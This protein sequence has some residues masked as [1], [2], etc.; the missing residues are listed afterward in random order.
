MPD[1][2]EGGRRC[3]TYH[4]ILYH[5]KRRREARWTAP[6]W[7]SVPG[8]C[9]GA[10]GA[11]PAA[12]GHTEGST[13]VQAGFLGRLINDFRGFAKPAG[14]WLAGWWVLPLSALWTVDLIGGRRGPT[15][16]QSVDRASV[17]VKSALAPCFCWP[18]SDTGRKTGWPGLSGCI[19]WLPAP[20]TTGSAT[21]GGHNAKAEKTRHRT[22]CHDQRGRTVARQ[23]PANAQEM[24]VLRRGSDR[25][26]PEPRQAVMGSGGYREA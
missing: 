20:S 13:I 11:A 22:D 10:G 23:A 8:R 2:P 9:G 26:N 5:V 6:G 17:D 3:W 15:D 18:A 24:G 16:F 12:G 14:W 4:I 19:Q 21:R 25:A 1:Q 7:R